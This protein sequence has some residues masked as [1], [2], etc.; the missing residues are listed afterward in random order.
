MQLVQCAALEHPWRAVVVPGAAPP[1]LVGRHGSSSSARMQGTG[2]AL[3]WN[4]ERAKGLA[5]FIAD[6]TRARNG[7]SEDGKGR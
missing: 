2:H 1:L 7:W 3:N 5:G 4:R 6:A